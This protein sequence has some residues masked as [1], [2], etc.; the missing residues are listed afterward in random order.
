VGRDNSLNLAGLVLVLF[1][2]FSA[3]LVVSQLDNPLPDWVR[4]GQRAGATEP[5]VALGPSE[6]VR[7]MIP[8]LDVDAPVHPVGLGD[9]GAIA[10]PPLERANETGWYEDGP[11]PGQYGA[12][13]IV[14]HV[15][16]RDGPAVFYGIKDLP[17]GSRIEITR[18]DGQVAV[19][20][21]TGVRTYPKERLPPDEVYG[22]FGEPAL[23]LITCGGEW[24]GGQAGYADS[25]IVFAILIDS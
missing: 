7:I 13:V 19:F 11:S 17:V 25:V 2:A 14:G 5:G 20:E 10:A 18:Q 21:V 4:W 24:V 22:D 6:P 3:G 15:D 1:G 12:A 9:D 23:R 16:D 8:S